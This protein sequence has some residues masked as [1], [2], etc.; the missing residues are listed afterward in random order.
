MTQEG[1]PQAK[2]WWGVTMAC[3]TQNPRFCTP[4]RQLQTSLEFHQPAPA[5]LILHG[6]QRVVH[7]GHSQSLQLTALGKPLP[8]TCQQQSRLNY[9]RRLYI[10]HMVVIT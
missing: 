2:H 4:S 9:K 1:W 3:I 8:L 5:Q 6:G 7:S 10:A